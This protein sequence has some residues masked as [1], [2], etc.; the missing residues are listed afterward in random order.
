MPRDFNDKLY[1]GRIAK[2]KVSIDS[3]VAEG[4]QLRWFQ[5]PTISSFQGT[6]ARE[7]SL[8]SE[9]ETIDRDKKAETLSQQGARIVFPAK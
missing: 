4:F 7:A 2:V 5:L 9:I 6:V 1:D 8:L 3:L